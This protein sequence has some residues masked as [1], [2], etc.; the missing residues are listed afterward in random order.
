MISWH[1]YFFISK[2]IFWWNLLDPMHTLDEQSIIPLEIKWNA[3]AFINKNIWRLTMMDWSNVE[4]Y[5][6]VIPFLQMRFTFCVVDFVYDVRSTI[7]HYFPL[8]SS[9]R[10]GLPSSF[11]CVYIPADRGL[12]VRK[13]IETS[14]G[15]N[16]CFRSYTNFIPDLTS[17]K[18]F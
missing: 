13:F 16:E 15:F 3:N 18:E 7:H 17:K 12:Y 11:S 5:L 9:I 1:E 6:H 10:F 2:W 4:A 14:F 8:N